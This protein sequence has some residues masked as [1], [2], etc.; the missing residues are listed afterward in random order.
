MRFL[1]CVHRTD[2]ATL[3]W[4]WRC[5]HHKSSHEISFGVCGTARTGCL[6]SFDAFSSSP[7]T[8]QP[9]SNIL[10]HQL[11]PSELHKTRPVIFPRG[12]QGTG[13][14]YAYV[15]IL[16]SLPQSHS[17]NEIDSP[18]VHHILG[19]GPGA[20]GL[21]PWP[22]CPWYIQIKNKYIYIYI[23]LRYYMW[24]NRIYVL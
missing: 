17:Q 20:P 9:F 11:L 3:L 24:D 23:Y 10:H 12:P 15:Y 5:R 8:P 21:G 19:P 2:C 4:A 18:S 1:L 16:K 13:T 22:M 6:S 14:I 7:H